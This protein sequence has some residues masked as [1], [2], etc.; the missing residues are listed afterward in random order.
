MSSVR[1]VGTR[2]AGHDSGVAASAPVQE[3]LRRTLG[4]ASR[5]RLGR[6]DERDRQNAPPGE[7]HN[8]ALERR[9]L[10]GSGNRPKTVAGN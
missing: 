3:C 1:S 10:P 5:V 4:I 2:S 7:Q 8:C 9:R 6:K